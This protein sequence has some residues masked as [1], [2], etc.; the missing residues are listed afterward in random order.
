MAR[1]A[2][3]KS[4]RFE[5]F[6]RDKFTCQY[7]GASAPDVILEIDHIRPVS[8]GGTNDILNL[9]TECRDCNSGKT[10][11]ELSDDSAVKVQKQ[12]LD[13]MQER[14][15][16][17]QMMLEWRDSLIQQTESEIDAIDSIFSSQTRWG[18]S[19]HGRLCIRKLIKKF[20]FNE[21]YEAAEIAIDRYYDGTEK[22]WDNAFNK[23]GGICYN[24]RKDREENAE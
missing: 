11:R 8:K 15:E 1:K 22:S 16:Q 24:R 12:R 17:L 6:K 20:G 14:R 3:P 9:V 5:V 10:N 23:V 13:D 7:C 4:V 21:V 19:E 18:F 2:I